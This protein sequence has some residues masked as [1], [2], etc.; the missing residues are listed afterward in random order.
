[1]TL[2]RIDIALKLAIVNGLTC[3]LL[4]IP[5]IIS[6]WKLPPILEFYHYLKQLTKAT[7]LLL[8]C[9]MKISCAKLDITDLNDVVFF[10]W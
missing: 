5:K 1:M 8:Y 9:L 6:Q 7:M 3:K 4:L 2:T 10:V